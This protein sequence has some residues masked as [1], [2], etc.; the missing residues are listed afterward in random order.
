[1]RRVAITHVAQS[2]GVESKESLMDFT[3]AINKEI[4]DKAGL[5]REEVGCIIAGAA[6]IFHSGLSCANAFDWDGIG[7]FLKEGSRAEESAFSFIYG[8]MRIMSGHFDTVIER[9]CC[10]GDAN[11]SISR[12]LRDNGRA[13][14][15]GRRQKPRQCPF[16]PLRSCKEKSEYKRCHGLGKNL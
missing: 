7:A 10:G 13:V 5:K 2:S 4:L 12:A 9:E 15:K 16:Q 1:M 14:R 11:A 6:D 3:Y 8:C